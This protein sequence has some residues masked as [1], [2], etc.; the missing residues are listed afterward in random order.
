MAE[1]RIPTPEQQKVIDMTDRTV[2]LSAAAGSGKTATLTERLIRMITRPENPLDVTRMLVVTFTRAAAEELRVRISEA[3]SSA[4]AEDPDNARLARQLLL[5]P[6]ARIRTIDAFCNDLVKGHTDTLGISPLYR[7]AD[8]GECDLLGASVFDEVIE[9]AFS[10]VFAPEGLD[11]ATVVEIAETVK[12]SGSLASHL[13]T[14]YKS[15]LHGIKDGVALLEKNADLLEKEASLPFFRTRAGAVLASHIKESA[16]HA[17]NLLVAAENAVFT[18]FGKDDPI[19]LTLSARYF[20][21]LSTADRIVEACEK[22]ELSALR[23]LVAEYELPEVAKCPRGYEYAPEETLFKELIGDTDKDLCALFAVTEFKDEDLASVFTDTARVSR[24]LFLLFAEFEERLRTEKRRRAIC[25]YD[26]ITQFAYSLLLDEKGRPTP[27]AEE[28]RAGFDAVCIDEYQDVNEIQHRIFEAIAREDCRFMVGDIKQSIYA[29]RGALPDIFGRLRATFPDPEKNDTRAV[30]YLTRNFRSEASVIDYANGVFKFLFP[31]IG[32]SIG[33]VEGK[34]ELHTE[35]PAGVTAAP[36]FYLMERESKQKSDEEEAEDAERLKTEDDLIAEKVASLLACG[37]KKD[38]TPIRP[39]DIAILSRE[40]P[41]ALIE[42]LKAHG[43]P[44]KTKD[45]TDFFS[46]PEIMLALSLCRTV[47]NPHNDIP[48]AGLLR[49]PLYGISLDLLV[50]V[51]DTQ[52][53]GSLFMALTSYGALHPEINASRACCPILRA[54]APWR[55]TRP[56]IA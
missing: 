53:T 37:K 49:S 30:L 11:I 29:F 28:M 4:V 2:L 44:L 13:Y 23:A 1:K 55:K 6:S 35:K 38:G 50:T 42:T 46:R 14:L 19:F 27:L 32:D 33:Y 5:L 24:S 9:D 39:S 15:R 7:I 36:T 16:T 34:D 51:R 10:G 18:H 22:D 54:S 8:E 48:L 41:Y 17:K 25:D 26:D 52:K 31:I 56:R 21:L 20:Y 40:Y 43:I 45:K 3:L 12:G 47:N